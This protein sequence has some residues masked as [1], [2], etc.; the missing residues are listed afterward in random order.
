MFPLL[1]KKASGS[2]YIL[3]GPSSLLYKN[4]LIKVDLYIFELFQHFST[5]IYIYLFFNLTL[6]YKF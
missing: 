6:F 4:F 1:F 2:E 3:T 5:Y